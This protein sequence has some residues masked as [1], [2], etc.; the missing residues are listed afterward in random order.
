M[1]N[2]NSPLVS[3]CM[4][5]Y[6]QAKYIVDAIEGVLAQSTNF[7]IELLIGEDCSNK[8]NTLEICR[9]YERN[10]PQIIRVVHDGRNYGMVANE[11]RLM[12]QAKGKYIAFCEA[13]DYWIDSLKLQKQADVLESNPK[14]SACACQ[15]RIINGTDKDNYR[16]QNSMFTTDKEITFIDL[17]VGNGGFQTASFLF[18]SKNIKEVPPLPTKINGWDRAV[19]LLNAYRG[20]IYWLKDEMAV[21][22]KNEDGISTWVTYDLMR[23][24]LGMV[25]WFEKIDS[26]FPVNALKVHIYE[27]IMGNSIVINVFQL[28]YCYLCVLFYLFMSELDLSKLK[29]NANKTLAYK[30]PKDFRRVLRKIGVIKNYA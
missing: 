17:L 19:F 29:V 28:I 3:I 14:F 13:D 15:S 27:A 21:Y 30:L 8:D 24:D 22:R 2:N 5:A 12:D 4:T 1:E 9:K 7:Q 11:Q 10:Y 25:K 23:R 16:L 18:R 20:N 6:N 26:K